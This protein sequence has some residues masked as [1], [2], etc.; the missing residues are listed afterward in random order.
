MSTISTIGLKPK[1]V[2]TPSKYQQAI[3]D[4]IPSE[5]GRGNHLIVEAVAG[6]G[7]TTTGIQAF[8]LLPLGMES[9]FVAFNKHIADE[10]N[11]RLG[12]AN[13][14]TY[15][16][17]GLST[18]KKTFGKVTIDIDKTEKYLKKVAHNDK[19]LYMPIKRLVGLCKSSGKLNFTFNYLENLA[20]AHSIDLYDEKGTDIKDRIFDL[21]IKALNNSLSIPEIVDFDDMIW[22][23]NVLDT[24]S[25][26]QYD[27]LF[28]DEVQDTNIAQLYLASH[29]IHKQGTIIGVGDRKQSIYRFRGADETAMDKLKG[30]L[31]AQELPLSISYRCPRVTEEMVNKKWPEIKFE[32]PEWA[33]EGK[34]T[35][36][37]LDDIKD[38][39]KLNDLI[40]CRVNADLVPVCF[41]LIRSGIKAVIRGRD[42]G[43]GLADL[44][45]KSHATYTPDLIR[46][47]DNWRDSEVEKAFKVGADERLQFIQDKFDTLNALIDGTE[48]VSEVITRCDEM[49]SDEKAGITLS[50]IHKAKGLEADRVFILRPD[51]IPHPAATSEADRSQES[52]LE[53]VAITRAKQELIY[54][55]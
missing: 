22:L 32:V 48:L 19:W 33:R 52:N 28:V 42:I 13:A 53:Y 4:W 9:A 2:F 16:A 23:P 45:R 30:Y 31:S 15:H 44:V 11:Q 29:S 47:L 8:G 51:L 10:L 14:K 43:K 5:I 20:F 24:V 36:I 49:F 18:I 50:T 38:N 1:P 55:R 54:V 35:N 3:F 21:V 34:L 27:F 37:L 41:D 26:F 46:W 25:F 7:K 6:S 12:G 40:L 39:I 17:L